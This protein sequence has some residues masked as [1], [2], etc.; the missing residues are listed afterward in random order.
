MPQAPSAVVLSEREVENVGT[1]KPSETIS[2]MSSEYILQSSSQLA[3]PATRFESA[4]PHPFDNDVNDKGAK[5]VNKQLADLDQHPSMKSAVSDVDNQKSVTAVFHIKG[6]KELPPG[7]GSIHVNAVTISCSC[8]NVSSKPHVQATVCDCYDD[9]KVANSR[10]LE[11]PRGRTEEI[12]L[13]DRQ[14]REK[15]RGGFRKSFACVFLMGAVSACV[16]FFVSHEFWRVSC[17]LVRNGVQTVT[18]ASDL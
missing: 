8:D 2:A 4:L 15:G 13:E 11:E 5:E 18:A 1:Q 3:Q 9:S 10:V 6:Y 14:S 17:Q 12:G 7:I 16:G